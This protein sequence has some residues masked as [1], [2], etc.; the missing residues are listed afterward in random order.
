MQ[1]PSEPTVLQA[2][3]S[4]TEFWPAIVGA[5]VGGS[6]ALIAQLIALREER[7]HRAEDRR[8]IQQAHGRALLVKTMHIYENFVEVHGKIGEGIPDAV[9]DEK[10]WS[11]V[12]PLVTFPDHIDFSAEELG[13]L[14]G[15]NH[16]DTFDKVRSLGMS[17]NSLVDATKVY[18]TERTS[19]ADRLPAGK[20]DTGEI[21]SHYLDEQQLAAL[22][23]RMI[24]LNSLI[25]QIRGRA[26]KDLSESRAALEML[27][28]ALRDKLD[29]DHPLE[30]VSDISSSTSP[31]SP[32]E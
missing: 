25:K 12:Q 29:L 4:A 10:L 1:T 9:E 17:H 8:L 6:L 19:L 14:L 26:Q 20:F 11:F 30:F 28:V 7:K 16:G 13:M 23:P 3:I 32:R 31:A 2:I 21:G 24:D 27:R 18:A 5:F 15:L 22:Q